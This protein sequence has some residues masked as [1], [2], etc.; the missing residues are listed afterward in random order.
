MSHLEDRITRW[1]LSKHD[2]PTNDTLGLIKGGKIHLRM[3]AGKFSYD[4]LEHFA[5]SIDNII[6]ELLFRLLEE[7][8]LFS[9]LLFHLPWLD[10]LLGGP[11]LKFFH[12]GLHSLDL[13]L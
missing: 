4:I 3:H 8:D 9:Q 1:L 13:L 6:V 5:I 11:L 12:L 10:F 7:L 2:F